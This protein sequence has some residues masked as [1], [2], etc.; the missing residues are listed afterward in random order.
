MKLLKLLLISASTLLFT[1]CCTCFP[2]SNTYDKDIVFVK[3]KPY[4]VPRGALFN[5]IPISEDVTIKDYNL[6]GKSH[7]KKGDLTWVSPK[8]AKELKETYRIDGADA[9]SY[10]YGEAI[11]TRRM[12]CA[13]ALSQS[14]YEYYKTKY[15]L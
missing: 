9:F 2:Q 6:Y 4:L 5:T 10:A 12:G 8:T 7:C 3:G 11:R 14:E 1:G 15:G 13:H